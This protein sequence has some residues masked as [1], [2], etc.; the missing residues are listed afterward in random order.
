MSNMLVTIV[1]AVVG[2]MQDV[3]V[4]GQTAEVD[5]LTFEIQRLQAD[6]VVLRASEP[7]N[8]D[9]FV[10]LLR[11]FPAL[12]V[13]AITGDGR[14]GFLHELRPYTMQLIELSTDQLE[15]AMRGHVGPKLN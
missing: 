1:S 3:V 13:V 12:K 9:D 11:R 8:T 10:P 2:Q 5:D 7:G 14:M 4:A 6:A 15:A